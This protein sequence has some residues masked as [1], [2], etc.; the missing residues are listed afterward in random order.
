[1][2]LQYA[3]PSLDNTTITVSYGT[4]I[5]I[6]NITNEMPVLIPI[7]TENVILN[8]D[9]ESAEWTYPQTPIGQNPLTLDLYTRI[10]PKKFH[11]TNKDTT[12]SRRTVHSVRLA[13]IGKYQMVMLCCHYLRV[14]EYNLH[15]E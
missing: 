10:Y 14:M 7:M 3:L 5:H 11:C 12:T 6:V 9:A 15:I 4:E 1:M 13:A 8:C 2:I